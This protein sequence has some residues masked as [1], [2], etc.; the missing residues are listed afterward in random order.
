[1]VLFVVLL[2][3]SG[4]FII[5]V[6]FGIFSNSTSTVNLILTMLVIFMGMMFLAFFPI[7][8]TILIVI[9]ILVIKAVLYLSEFTMRR[10]AESPKGPILA[11]SALAGGIAAVV[12]VFG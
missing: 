5:L 6:L 4:L 11:I 3:S 10:I 8:L 7:L 12:K 2:T 1:M 9:G